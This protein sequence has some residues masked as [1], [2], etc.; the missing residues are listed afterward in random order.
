MKTNYKVIIVGGGASGLLCAV[1]LLSGQNRLKGSDVLILEANDRVGKKLVATGNGQG[2]VSNKNFSSQHYHGDKAFV[3]A[4]VE[5][6]NQINIQ[7]YLS[8]LGI[9][10]YTAEDGKQYPISKQA[11]SVLDIIRLFLEKNG[12]IIQTSSRVTNIQCLSNQFSIQVQNQIFNAEK[13]VLAFGGKSAK[14]FG[15]DGTSYSLA[16]SLGHSVTELFPSLV[17]LKT[18][19]QKIKGLKG[20]KEVALVSAYSG[21]KFLTKAKGDILFTEYGVSGSAVFLVS[22]YLTDCTNPN[23]QIEFLPDYSLE[24]VEQM[25]CERASFNYIDKENFLTGIINKKIG[26]SIIKDCGSCAPKVIANKLKNFKLEVTGNLGFNY[27]QVTKGGVDTKEILIHTLQSKFNHNAYIVGEALNIDG[28][29]GGYNLTFAFVTG[30]LSAKH[31]KD[32][33]RG[34]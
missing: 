20:L 3:N 22:S 4:F 18:S 32:T 30:I 21:E 6:A 19:T 27:S 17:Q 11:N 13:L 34:N 31:I 25:L 29:C 28:D 1:E 15:T 26:Q 14:Q 33:L 16:K 24:Q 7:N 8:N 23:I 5:D 2:N 9:P 10:L 12:C